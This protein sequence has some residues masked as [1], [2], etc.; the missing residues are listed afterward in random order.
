MTKILALDLGSNLGF[1]LHDNGVIVSGV[2]SFRP[3]KKNENKGERW[4]RLVAFLNIFLL[5]HSP[6][7]VAYEKV[8]NHKGIQAS[9]MYGAYEAILELICYKL[10][11]R[12]IPLEVGHIKK[13]F[14]G[15]GNASK[16][17]IIDECLNR[18]FNPKN[19]ATSG[20][21]T[22]RIEKCEMEGR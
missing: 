1:A 10:N 8:R 9:H 2:E 22:R 21:C 18:G 12:L 6:K 15:R 7:I 4:E 20:H 13:H 17:M 5:A 16:E 14:T 19:D 11:I 3:K